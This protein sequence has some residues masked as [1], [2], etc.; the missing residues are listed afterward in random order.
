MKKALS[1]LLVLIIMILFS[2][3]TKIPE[4]T[5]IEKNINGIISELEEEKAAKC[6]DGKKDEWEECDFSGAYSCHSYFPDLIGPY[7]CNNC[8]HDLSKCEKEDECA[9]NNCTVNAMCVESE[10]FYIIKC[11]CIEPYKGPDCHECISGFHNDFDGTCINDEICSLIGC[12][13]EKKECRISTKGYAECICIYP[14][15]GENCEK[16]E[17][18]YYYDNG[19][20]KESSCMGVECAEYEIC[21][22]DR[23][24]TPK[25]FC[26]SENQNPNDCSQCKPGYCW[27]ETKNDYYCVSE[28][29][30][31]C[32]PNTSK[33]ENSYDVYEYDWV[34]CINYK[35]DTPECQWECLDDYYKIDN[36]CRLATILNE[37]PEFVLVSPS[38]EGKIIMISPDGK[39][40]NYVDDK[41][42]Y[43][44]K[45]PVEFINGARV[46][47]DGNYYLEYADNSS[48]SSP[49]GAIMTPDGKEIIKYELNKN[50]YAVTTFS[51]GGRIFRGN[52]ELTFPYNFKLYNTESCDDVSITLSDKIL[53]T[54]TVCKNGMIFSLDSQLQLKWEKDF[55]SVR[56]HA[57]FAALGNEKLIVPFETTTTNEKGFYVINNN[58]GDFQTIWLPYI[59][60]D[61]HYDDTSIA[62]NDNYI[63]VDTGKANLYFYNEDYNI[64][65]EGKCGLGTDFTP[66]L[67]DNGTIAIFNQDYQWVILRNSELEELWR[68]KTDASH[69]NFIDGKVFTYAIY[70]NG[71]VFSVPGKSEGVWPQYLHDSRLSGSL[72]DISFTGTPKAPEL[73]SPANNSIITEDT[74]TFL[75]SIDESDPDV[76]YT[77]LLRDPKGFDKVVAGPQKGLTSFTMSSNEVNTYEWKVVSRN[78]SGSLNVSSP[79]TVIFKGRSNWVFESE[80]EIEKSF[81]VVAQNGDIAIQ[82]KKYH[83]GVVDKDGNLKS[84]QHFSTIGANNGVAMNEGF[85]FTDIGAFERFIDN[86][87]IRYETNSSGM[88]QIVKHHSGRA[89]SNGYSSIYRVH[90]FENET[91]FELGYIN[92]KLYS[93]AVISRDGIV[94]SN[95]V[96]DY[97]GEL[98]PI[99]IGIIPL[100]I[101][102]SKLLYIDRKEMRRYLKNYSLLTWDNE[103]GIE[104]EDVLVFHNG[105]YY[106]LL[107]S[108]GICSIA[109]YQFGETAFSREV[110]SWSCDGRITEMAVSAEGV[111]FLPDGNEVV[112][113][114]EENG[115]LWRTKIGGEKAHSI[116]LTENGDLYAI[117]GKRLISLESGSLGADPLEWSQFRAN[118]Q[119]TACEPAETY[120]LMPSLKL[121][122]PVKNTVITEDSF[123]FSWESTDPENESLTFDFNLG[124]M[125]NSKKKVI[126]SVEDLTEKFHEVIGQLPE[127]TTVYWKV[128]AKDASGTYNV[129]ESVFTT[130]EFDQ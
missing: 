114:K 92:E 95:A 101:Q 110:Y 28:M 10:N 57:Q 58:T 31:Q 26:K 16:C 112:A 91:D 76:D 118:A 109:A 13:N 116:T 129:K 77:L 119:R 61:T 102:N 106:G 80:N 50:K 73:I 44:H 46:L 37:I 35:W 108:D 83:I 12:Q 34:D 32:L 71:S 25:C 38:K 84:T 42:V 47:P 59:N 96:T 130:S 56:I 40:Y 53:N 124:I 120:N 99:P 72:S 29:R 88:G 21:D 18:G 8:K 105:E 6:G 55:S 41:V 2:G 117:S 93:N 100:M 5:D 49:W 86:T 22:Y 75:W 128:T 54:Y 113:I 39:L 90:V 104:V 81:P 48:S 11:K 85:L 79:S 36:E 14:Y 89:F 98:S 7:Y 64:V 27:D 97:Y 67:L 122:S 24:G 65:K 9:S 103:S 19:I 115:E 82:Y 125:E 4:K 30:R 17:Y 78:S 68:R 94:V 52:N 74:V 43:V 51:K 62:I 111:F 60:T 3:C 127:K 63:V 20:C 107:Y 123:T 126:Y 45:L 23:N 66:V 121:L 33:P 70:G 1:F 69:M 15:L 87:W